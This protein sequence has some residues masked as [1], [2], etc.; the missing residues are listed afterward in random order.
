M[1]KDKIINVEINNKPISPI[2]LLKSKSLLKND[3]SNCSLKLEN[4]PDFSDADEI[5]YDC[6]NLALLTLNISL[7]E[8]NTSTISFSLY[9]SP[10]S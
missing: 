10:D 9:G 3:K 7:K 8:Y 6:I 5:I 4:I 2:N 1:F